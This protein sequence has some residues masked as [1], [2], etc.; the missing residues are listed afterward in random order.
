MSAGR[1]RDPVWICF[2]ELSANPG[3]TGCRA[4]CK[5]CGVELQGLVV[6]LKD[7]KL[8]CKGLES[9]ES[10]SDAGN[11]VTNNSTMVHDS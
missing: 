1:K 10:E 4:R 6:R 11:A 9:A 5:D 3:K 2:K 7:H 8:K